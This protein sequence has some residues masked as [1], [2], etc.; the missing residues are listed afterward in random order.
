[1]EIT[2]DSLISLLGIL[3]GGGCGAFFTWKWQRKK[4]EAEAQQ[5]QAEAKSAEV[6][7]AQKVQDTYQQMLEDKD[8]EVQDKNRI[9]AELREDRD[10]YRQTVSEMMKRQDKMEEEV[11][12]LKEQVARNGRIMKDIRPFLCYVTNCRKRQRA[13]TF[14]T[15]CSTEGGPST[16][17]GTAEDARPSTGSGTASVG[18]DPST[19][20]GTANDD[21]TTP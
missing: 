3:F 2:F 9:I 10:H 13:Q 5:Q 7:M 11:R 16:S 18:D 12:S 15:T 17:S 8:K 4:A 14:P 20:S 21:T 6:D 1:M 19:S